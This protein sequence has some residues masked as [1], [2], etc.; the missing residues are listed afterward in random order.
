MLIN[1]VIERDPERAP[2]QGVA[3]S[4][5]LHVKETIPC[6][7]DHNYFRSVTR[8]PRVSHLFPAVE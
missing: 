1:R 3:R 7:S 5:R 2:P 6:R 8:A 4:K